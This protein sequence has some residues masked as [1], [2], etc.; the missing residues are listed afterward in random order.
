[1]TTEQ[2]R[3]VA[4]AIQNL[5]NRLSEASSAAYAVAEAVK[6]SGADEYESDIVSL[7][8][9]V[10]D[11]LADHMQY[12]KLGTRQLRDAWASACK[13]ADAEQREQLVTGPCACGVTDCR[14]T[15]VERVAKNGSLR[16]R[17]QC[18][19]CNDEWDLYFDPRETIVGFGLD[20]LLGNESGVIEL[21]NQALTIE[22]HWRKCS[23]AEHPEYLW[24]AVVTASGEVKER[25]CPLRNRDA[26]HDEALQIAAERIEHGIDKPPEP[27]ELTPCGDCS[28]PTPEAEL[29]DGGKVGIRRC[30]ECRAALQEVRDTPHTCLHCDHVAPYGEWGAH[31]HDGLDWCTCP[32]CGKCR[33][34]PRACADCRWEDAMGSSEVCG[35]C[36]LDRHVQAD[37][38][39]C[40]R[41]GAEYDRGGWYCPDCRELPHC[42]N[43]GKLY[44]DIDEKNPHGHEGSGFCETCH[45]AIDAALNAPA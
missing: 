42:L 19:A 12:R 23:V 13:M 1:M 24:R 6:C 14:P 15:A 3:E 44:A 10:A 30:P 27:P 36:H 18:R 29:D 37:R 32:R 39:V 35:Q 20:E 21:P 22:L 31:A 41:C 45:T 26:A 38:K 5:M 40:A 33:I 16:L 28:K 11:T 7:A 8:G 43:C 9:K 17:F 4:A 34:C 2:R 25:C